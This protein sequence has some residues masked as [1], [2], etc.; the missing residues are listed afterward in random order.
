MSSIQTPTPSVASTE[1][2][3]SSLASQPATT[4][5]SDRDSKYLTSEWYTGNGVIEAAGDN[6]AFKV[7]ATYTLEAE[8]KLVKGVFN[9]NN[10]VLA[11]VYRHRGR[12]VAVVDQ[13]V[14]ELYGD[15]L[16]Q[17][18]EYYEIP[19]EAKVLRAWEADKTPET[20]YEILGFLG[21]DGCDVSRNEPVL[22]VGG[23][24]LSDVAGLACALQHRRTPYVMVGTTVVAAI[25]AGP[26][27]RT[28]TNGKQFKNSIGAYHPP[29]LTLV[30]RGFFR[31]LD[32]GHIRNGMAEII[33]MAITDDPILFDLMEAH[34]LQLLETHFAT[35]N[36]DAELEKIADEV[37]YRALYSYMKHEGTNMFETYQDRPHSYG[38]TWS[39]RF[40]PAVKMMHGHAVTTGMAFG[41][42]L[43]V[44]MGWLDAAE[45]DRIVN[46]C[47]SLG[48]TVYHPILE[49][50]DLMV[51]GQKNMQ[52]KRGSGGLWVA[53]PKGEIGSCDYAREIS[54]ETLTA[55]VSQHKAY[56]AAFPNSGAGQQMYLKDLG[57]E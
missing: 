5:E 43:A 54:R 35:L 21:K 52:R 57:L 3:L 16:R 15:Q 4:I 14:D 11:E 42:T 26:S 31:T 13:T 32:V 41:A 45:R 18:F 27:P 46:L 2:L 28:C 48:L 25:D 8:V 49:D 36:A 40:E 17:Y 12:C 24:V 23:G 38:H 51:E 6:R 39:P 55:A 10:P 44:T 29:V 50:L 1:T 9:V 33:K 56:C 7:T 34:G 22:V 37:I 20:V 47:C 53:L 30:D 19:L